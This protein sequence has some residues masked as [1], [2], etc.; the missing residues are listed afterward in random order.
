M[1]TGEKKGE[2]VYNSQPI[3]ALSRFVGIADGHTIDCTI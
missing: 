1:T 3:L 2:K